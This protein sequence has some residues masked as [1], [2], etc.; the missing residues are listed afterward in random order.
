VLKKEKWPIPADIEYEYRGA[1]TST[2][3]A[4][5]CWTTPSR[6]WRE[7]SGRAW[8]ARGSLARITSTPCAAS[9][10]STSPW[11]RAARPPRAGR[12]TRWRRRHGSFE[13]LAA[14]PD[15]HVVHNTT[16]NYLHVPVILAALAQGST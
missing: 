5:R 3:E 6:R 14:D 2:E 12:P 13:D 7:A 10:S 15:V 9:V 1:G 4:R 8:S 11:R 16:P